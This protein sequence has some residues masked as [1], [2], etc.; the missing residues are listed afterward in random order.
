MQSPRPAGLLF[1]RFPVPELCQNPIYLKRLE[2]LFERRLEIR[3]VARHYGEPVFQRWGRD[4]EIGAV[5]AYAY[6]FDFLPA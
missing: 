3:Y 6:W 1:G 4:H 5:I 2:L